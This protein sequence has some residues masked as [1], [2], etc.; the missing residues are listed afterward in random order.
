M[1]TNQRPTS[2]ETAVISFVSSSALTG[3]G[4][5]ERF[6]S[7]SIE[8][9]N[10]LLRELIGGGDME[11]E[12][13]RRLLLDGSY[14]CIERRRLRSLS[15]LFLLLLRERRCLRGGVLLRLR[16]SRF[17]VV[18]RGALFRASAVVTLELVSFSGV[19]DRLLPRRSGLSDFVSGDGDLDFVTARRDLGAGERLIDSDVLLRD[20]RGRG[21]DERD[22]G[23]YER[24]RVRRAGLLTLPRP[25]LPL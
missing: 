19:A 2:S 18:L 5:A 15:P 17:G 14:L 16:L 11:E 21:E 9:E 24:R 12:E 7:F 13:L 20:L 1:T 6:S 10:F 8:P 22:D 4:L 3:A 25:P 23:V